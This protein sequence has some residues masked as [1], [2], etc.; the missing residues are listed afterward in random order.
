MVHCSLKTSPWGL[1]N[2][3][4]HSLQPYKKTHKCFLP[5]ADTKLCRLDVN[6]RLLI[7]YK[8]RYRVTPTLLLVFA[9]FLWSQ[10]KHC[11]LSPEMCSTGCKLKLWEK[12]QR[13]RN[14]TDVCF[15]ESASANARPPQTRC[16]IRHWSFSHIPLKWQ[17]RELRSQYSDCVF[18]LW[19]DGGFALICYRKLHIL[20]PFLLNELFI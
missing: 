17:V 8:S 6:H 1:D 12:R 9:G 13:H 11:S 5:A 18:H 7:K 15:K 2:A 14:G 10:Q 16:D 3:N 4:N 19:C 20:S